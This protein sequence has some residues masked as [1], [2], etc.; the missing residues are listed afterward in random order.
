[1]SKQKNPLKLIITGGLTVAISVLIIISIVRASGYGSLTPS[2]TP[3]A[4]GY[5]LADIYN[6][7]NSNT[8][9]VAGNHTFTAGAT[10]SNGFYTLVDVYDKIPTINPSNL[11]SSTTY[12]GV[13]GNIAIRGAFGLK[14]STT[15]QS[16]AA[17]YYSGGTLSG[18][19]TL[20][21]GNIKNGVNIFGTIGNYT[22]GG[23]VYGD[24]DPAKVLT[25]ATSNLG[26]SSYLADNLAVGKVKY[27]TTFGIGPQTGTLYGD[28]DASKVCSTASAAGTVSVTASL[29]ATSTTY[30]G[31]TGTLLGHLFNG[32][33]FNSHF[34]TVGTEYLGGS[35][36]NGGVDDYNYG[37]AMPVGAYSANWTKCTANNSY[38]GTND[39][40]AYSKDNATGLIWSNPCASA[41]CT[42]YSSSSPTAYQW[43]SKGVNNY[44]VGLGTAGSS[45]ASQLCSNDVNAVTGGGFHMGGWFLPHQKQFMM[46]YIDGSYGSLEIGYTRFFWTATTESDSVTSAHDFNLGAGTDTLNSK[47]TAIKVRC[48]RSY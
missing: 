11:L 22:A 29:V 8:P 39:S 10:S 43:N 23:Y 17:G 48:V 19:A 26:A 42:T 4:T 45:T 6:R 24:N 30:C 46:A 34:C 21:P 47:S 5:T 16:V 1:M 3:T 38:C 44:Y 32:T 9:A 20:I 2:G 27:G 12:L 41:G 14:G 13:T 7:L 31:V 36:A 18:S 37:A 35:Q 25:A 33:C 15:D 40:F 28:T